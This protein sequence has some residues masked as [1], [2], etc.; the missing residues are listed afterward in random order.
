MNTTTDPTAF[1]ASAPPGPP[2]SPA[3]TPAT[4]SA[5]APQVIERLRIDHA[6]WQTYEKFLDAIGDLPLR[7]T[8]D[9][10]KLEIMAPLRVHEREKTLLA[11]MIERIAYVLDC[12][13]ESCGS[14][15][16]RRADLQ[17]GFEPDECF[18]IAHATQM[19]AKDEPDFTVD[20]PPDLAIESDVTSS[21][22]DRQ[23][24]YAT[25]GIPELWRAQKNAVEFFVLH[26]GIYQSSETSKSFPFLTATDVNRF[27]ALPRALGQMEILK[28]FESWLRTVVP[29]SGE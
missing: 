1:T 11:S 6:D 7:C 17:R 29:P 26:D 5:P 14:M 13:L 27:L 16:I 25:I 9:R 21:S 22:I 4:A 12:P 20:P 8:Y 10:G 15:T 28:R 2:T 18:Y 19:A 3:P 24:L 23:A